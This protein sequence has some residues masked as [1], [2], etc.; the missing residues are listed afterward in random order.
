MLKFTNT[1][2]TAAVFNGAFF[3]LESPEDWKSIGDGPTRDAVFA[4][5]AKGNTPLPVY[6]PPWAPVKAALL[7][8]VR[9]ARE[10][11]IDRLGGIAGRRQRAGDLATAQACDAAVLRLLDLT[12]R[13]DVLAAADAAQLRTAVK[14][15]Y[16]EAK[17]LLPVAVQNAFRG[18][19][20]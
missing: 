16:A 10:Q 4:W 5:L 20:A 12:S 9:I 13:P 1:Q 19:D 3:S 15:G 6:V 14:T 17:A 7:D 8:G 18:L 2:K 11:I